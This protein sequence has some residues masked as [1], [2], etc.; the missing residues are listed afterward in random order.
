MPPPLD[1]TDFDFSLGEEVAFAPCTAQLESSTLVQMPP[2]RLPSPEPC[3]RDLADQHQKALGDAL[4]AN[5]QVG[6]LKSPPRV[7][8]PCILLGQLHGPGVQH[9]LA[10]GQWGC[11]NHPVLSCPSQLQET[12]TQKQEELVTLQESNVQLKELATQARQLAAI[13]DVSAAIP[14]GSA[15]PQPG[16]SLGTVH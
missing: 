5:S 13:L 7:S 16:W 2:Q 10:P 15:A 1:Y 9:P 12:L 6:T 3:W 14:P 4:E 8:L 11:P